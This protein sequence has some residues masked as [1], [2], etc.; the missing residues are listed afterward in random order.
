MDFSQNVAFIDKIDKC[1]KEVS[2][3]G[4][5]DKNDIPAIVLLITELIMDSNTTA[6]RKNIP[7]TEQISASIDSLYNYI[8]THYKLFPE[9]EQQKTAFKAM[10]DICVKLALFQPNANKGAKSLF[11]CL[12]GEKKIKSI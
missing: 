1:I 4:K 7:T 8:M 12:C 2:K 3:D 11:A 9:D 10:F 5:L 6:S